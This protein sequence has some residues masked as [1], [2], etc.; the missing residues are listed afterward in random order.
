MASMSSVYT[1]GRRLLAAVLCPLHDLPNSF[2]G[3][4]LF[5]LLK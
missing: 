2:M 5:L 4:I 3:F 1:S